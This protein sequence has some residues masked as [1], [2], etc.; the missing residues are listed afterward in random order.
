AGK[1]VPVIAKIEKHEAIEQMEE[2]LTLCNGVMVARGDL[3]VELPAEDVPILQKR[4]IATSNRLGI[5]V[6]TATQMLDSMVSNPR[7]TRA[8]IS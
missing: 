6:I 8:E 2:I 4:L 7:P 3:G 5:P 1:Q